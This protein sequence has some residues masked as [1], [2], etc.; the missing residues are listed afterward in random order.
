MTKNKIGIFGGSFNPVHK[1]H[2][3][4]AEEFA[5]DFELDL[6]Y[7]IPNRI[8]PFKTEIQVSGEDRTEMLRLAFSRNS[9]VIIGNMELCREGASYTCDTIAQIKAI[10]QYSKLYLLVGDDH[11]KSFNKWKNSKYI[12]EN[13]Q[14]VVAARSS[15]DLKEDIKVIEAEGVKVELLNNT[16]F[17]CSSST[18]RD[19]LN[20]D[21]LPERVYEYIKKRGLYGL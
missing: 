1:G 11:V 4:I 15:L 18:L 3:L 9:R 13:T 6:L 2:V 19:N 12:L 5:K 21:Y 14:L 7:V 20:A 17:E 16:P 10:H 8:S